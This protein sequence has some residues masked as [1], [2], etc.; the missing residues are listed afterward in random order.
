MDSFPRNFRTSVKNGVLATSSAG[1]TRPLPWEQALQ[2][3]H[4]HTEQ[5]RSASVFFLSDKCGQTHEY[6]T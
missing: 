1:F 3:N 2:A 6:T 5:Y 4:M